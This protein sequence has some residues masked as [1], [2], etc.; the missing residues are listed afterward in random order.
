MSGDDFEAKLATWY[1]ALTPA[2]K[3]EADTWADLVE[4]RIV[5]GDGGVAAPRGLLV[6]D[7][8][9]PWP[10]STREKRPPRPPHLYRGRK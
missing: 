6:A 10:K 5:M 3:T 8:F 9:A 1:D 4:A 7:E 2:Q